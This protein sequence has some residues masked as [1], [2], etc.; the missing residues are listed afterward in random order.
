MPAC[1]GIWK[2]VFM[3]KWMRLA[4]GKALH[5][6]QIPAGT[7]TLGPA[8]LHWMH[9]RDALLLL[10]EQGQNSNNDL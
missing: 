9:N 7:L 1:V 10:L 3:G 6:S 4:S 8:W 2:G 5:S